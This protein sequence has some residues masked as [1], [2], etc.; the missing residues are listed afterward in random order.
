MRSCES[1][2][3][4]LRRAFPPASMPFRALGFGG[5]NEVT[6]DLARLAVKTNLDYVAIGTLY[7]VSMCSLQS[8]DFMNYL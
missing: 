1:I 3:T 5:V 6:D 7:Y 8:V 2:G 4:E